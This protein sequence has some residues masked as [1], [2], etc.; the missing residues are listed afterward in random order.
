MLKS[1]FTGIKSWLIFSVSKFSAIN[2]FIHYTFIWVGNFRQHEMHDMNVKS[3]Y[4]A[5]EVL[6]QICFKYCG[7]L[8]I[9][10]RAASRLYRSNK[11]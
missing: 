5:A 4:V 3:I 6:T 8:I 7:N 10:D 11:L 2:C 9:L 1:E